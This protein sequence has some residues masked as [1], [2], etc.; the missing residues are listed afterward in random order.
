[1]STT[2]NR[3]I[4]SAAD[5]KYGLNMAFDGNQPVLDFNYLRLVIEAWN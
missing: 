4:D 1:M 5:T 3:M 2:R